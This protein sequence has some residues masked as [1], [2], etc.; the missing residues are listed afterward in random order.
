[1]V[2]KVSKFH[3]WSH[4]VSSD[5]EEGTEWLL[6]R[7]V[8]ESQDKGADLWTC[9]VPVPPQNCSSN[10]C[11]SAD[12]ASPQELFMQF[13]IYPA[14]RFEHA[15]ATK[16]LLSSMRSLMVRKTDSLGVM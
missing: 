15:E 3:D 4:D 13:L 10:L 1:M 8:T 5:R 9:N 6:W 11:V 2:Y 14:S 12:T 7:A 16:Y